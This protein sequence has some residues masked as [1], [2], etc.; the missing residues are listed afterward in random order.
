MQKK[1]IWIWFRKITGYREGCRKK[2]PCEGRGL[3]N[4]HRKCSWDSVKHRKDEGKWIDR[5]GGRVSICTEG[6]GSGPN[7]PLHAINISKSN[8]GLPVADSSRNILEH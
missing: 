3:W 7:H 4:N 2:L 6:K 1:R 8:T 5:H